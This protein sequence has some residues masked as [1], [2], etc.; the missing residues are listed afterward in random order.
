ML[1]PTDVLHVN[2]ESILVCA[3]GQQKQLLKEPLKQLPLGM[4]L[5]Q[6]RLKTT[7]QSMERGDAE[8]HGFWERGRPCIFDVRITDT[9]AQ[10]YCNKDV[11]KVLAAQEKEKKDKYLK[12]CHEMRKDFTPMVYSVNGVAGREARSAEKHLATASAAK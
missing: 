12:A 8:V 1:L 5:E 11:P 6:R 7:T 10:S 4:L 3:A 9:D 2:L